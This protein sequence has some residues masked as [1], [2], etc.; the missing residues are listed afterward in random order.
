M[1][2]TEALPPLIKSAKNQSVELSDAVFE[3][4][5]NSLENIFNFLI[6]N[7]QKSDEILK[8][9]PVPNLKSLRGKSNLNDLRNVNKLEN[10]L[11]LCEKELKEQKVG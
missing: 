2:L 6:F 11:F 3:N 8:I 9:P 10:L 4:L 1:S 5:S 7:I